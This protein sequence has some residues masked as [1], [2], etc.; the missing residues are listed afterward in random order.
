MDARHP[1]GSEVHRA[2]RKR[3]KR[4]VDEII[5]L[6]LAKSKAGLV[7]ERITRPHLAAEIQCRIKQFMEENYHEPSRHIDPCDEAPALGG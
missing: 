2:T 5:E 3:L 4:L 7:F 6:M 1:E